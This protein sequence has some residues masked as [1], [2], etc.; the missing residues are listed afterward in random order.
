MLALYVLSDMMFCAQELLIAVMCD[1]HV[2]K[3]SCC[4]GV[5]HTRWEST[6]EKSLSSGGLPAELCHSQQKQH[7]ASTELPGS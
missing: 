6:W 4:M 1:P 7:P 2:S 5:T 3:Q